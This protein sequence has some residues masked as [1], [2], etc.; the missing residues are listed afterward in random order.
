MKFI[1]L[2]LPQGLSCP[3]SEQKHCVSNFGICSGVGNRDPSHHVW[4]AEEISPGVDLR[5]VE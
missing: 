5:H 2:P 1:F 4:G 3:A